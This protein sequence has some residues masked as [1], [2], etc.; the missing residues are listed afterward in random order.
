M[1]FRTLTKSRFTLALDCPRKL[2]YVG[3]PHYVDAR[4]DDEFL[5][6]LADGG[7]QI[8][9]L[10]RLMHPD[11]VLVTGKTLEE[12]LAQ[13]QRWLESD[14]AVVFEATF[15]VDN[16]V[17]RVDVLVKR[18]NDVQLIEVKS[19]SYDPDVP[20]RSF[21]TR[22]GGFRAGWGPYFH[23]VAFQTYVLRARHPNWQVRSF[24]MLVD[25]NATC[26]VES[27]GTQIRIQRLAVPLQIEVAPTLDVGAIVP[28]LLRQY[29]VTPDV[30]AIIGGV[31]ETPQGTEPFTAL[32][33]RLAELLG[34][35]TDPQPSPGAQCRSCEF[36]ADPPRRT[37]ST[38]SGWA[39]CLEAHCQRP[40]TEARTRTIFGLTGPAQI[41]DRLALGQL[42]L[43]R[44]ADDAI[45]VKTEP[46]KITPT[47]RQ[48][49]Q[50]REVRDHDPAPF[51]LRKELR[52]VLESLVFPLH[53]IDFETSLPVLPFHAG[54]RPNQQIL[55]QYSHHVLDHTGRLEHRSQS[56][57]TDPGVLPHGR[58]LR[59]MRAALG[60][61]LGSII[62]WWNHE[63]TVLG[64]VRDQLVESAEPDR[65]D[66]VAFIDAV[67]ARPAAGFGRLVDLGL[68]IV[69]RLAFFPGTDGRS[70][71]K[72]VLPAVL[73]RS[74]FLQAR[75]GAP[76]Y[77][78]PAMPSLN[79]APG[80][81]WVQR[82]GGQVLDP[83]RLLGPL[84]TDHTVEE[85]MRNGDAEEE[86][87]ASA[88]VANGGAAMV[89]YAELQRPDL[90]A[91]ERE[92]YRRELLR[93]CELDSLA[94]VM[95]YE[96]LR[97][98]VRT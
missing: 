51:L 79:F 57:E 87:S 9:E 7:H 10:A 23:D 22:D 21:R 25:R 76:V 49:L 88:F 40:V 35:G 80:W 47:Q 13:T 15:Q 34:E 5:K 19:K 63:R 42:E 69:S 8:G 78:T 64:N 29:D 11:G 46:G 27:L 89:A 6:S 90:P 60:N 20:A 3:D 85:A 61:D 62:H 97:E 43:S 86:G 26:P 33:R 55:F 82:D 54:R 73:Q 59:A 2:K 18:G 52:E 17:C 95:I 16:L 24:L 36:Y 94:M 28:P 30:D 70:S 32:V 14:H 31:V 53:F 91:A 92:R 72:K 74:D 98:W 68:P 38:R 93:Y 4:K 12:Q 81:T 58:V 84:F 1:Q 41:E 39:E 96:A 44:L 75:Y 45:I 50:L 83:Y 37:D 65:D 48:W 77:G 67:L 66:L 71:I 56:L